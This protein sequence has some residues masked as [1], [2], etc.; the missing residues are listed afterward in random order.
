MTDA[1]RPHLHLH[2]A[3]FAAIGKEGS[4]SL[5]IVQGLTS[6]YS[7]AHDLRLLMIL[8]SLLQSEPR[9]LPNKLYC[10]NKTADH[11]SPQLCSF[12]RSA[13]QVDQKRAWRRNTYPREVEQEFPRPSKPEDASYAPENEE[14]TAIH[15]LLS[16]LVQNGMAPSSALHCLDTLLSTTAQCSP[17]S[18]TKNSCSAGV[19]GIG[20]EDSAV[21]IF[22]VEGGERGVVALKVLPD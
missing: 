17:H 21:A 19:T 10:S 22:E 6:H 3:I 16:W 4:K 14:E 11:R 12:G 1:L 18:L 15:D 13:N 8:A 7:L 9:A 2:L 5:Y 20:T